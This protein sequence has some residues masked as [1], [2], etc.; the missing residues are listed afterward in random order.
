M[1]GIGTIPVFVAVVENSGFAA[2]A[3]KLGVSKSA[4]SKRITQLEARLGAQ[5][6]HRSTRKLSLTEAGERYFAHAIEALSAAREAEDAVF[7]LQ[8]DPKGRLKINVPMSFGRLHVAPLIADILQHHPK[9]EI[10]MIMD[11]RIVDLVEGGF[12][13]AIRTGTLPDSVLVARKL[14]P[15]RNILC[16]APSYLG[17]QGIPSEPSDLT[18]HN[19]LH[20]A[21]FSDFHEWT[22]RGAQEPIKVRTNGS[23]Q[24]NN[25]E[26]LLE[27]VIDGLGVGRFPTFIAGPH[28]AT[29]RLV[30]LLKS[31]RMPEQTIYAIFPER[32]HR[33][34]KVRVLVDYLAQRFSGNQPYWDHDT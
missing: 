28:I 30:R 33:P 2:A 27:A 24:V 4:V 9:I 1:Q 19:C 17:R 31:Y 10:D 6:L 12:D 34:L 20:Y 26:A 5:L 3:R 22:F 25:G 8:R 13:M 11:D 14:A 16:A 15:C 23:Y 18:N 29:G 32:R 7:E 21:Y